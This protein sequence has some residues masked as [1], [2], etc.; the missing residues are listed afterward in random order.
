MSGY[1]ELAVV[2]ILALVCVRWVAAKL[3]LPRPAAYGFSVVFVIV[4][5]TLWAEHMRHH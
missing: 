3:R 2:T 1:I 5:L 4:A